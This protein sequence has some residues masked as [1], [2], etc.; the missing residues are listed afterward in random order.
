MTA[1]MRK[2]NYKSWVSGL[3]T[4]THG[5]F[6]WSFVMYHGELTYWLKTTKVA[7][8]ATKSSIPRGLTQ[9]ATRRLEKTEMPKIK[10]KVKQR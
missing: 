10:Y 3:F 1:S 2:I 6:P 8:K 7:P 4:T 5:S 9:F